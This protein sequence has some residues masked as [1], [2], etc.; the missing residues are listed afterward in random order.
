MVRVGE[1]LRV[2]WL[3]VG[4]TWPRL[5]ATLL[6]RRGSG[7]GIR[8]CGAGEHRSTKWV[9][10]VL[11]GLRLCLPLRLTRLQLGGGRVL[12]LCAVGA[13]DREIESSKLALNP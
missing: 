5:L 8:G 13:G 4:S 1:A 2:R 11:R 3:R 12:C 7:L 10:R 9:D 6:V